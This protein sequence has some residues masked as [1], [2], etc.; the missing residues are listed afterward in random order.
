MSHAHHERTATQDPPRAWFHI[1]FSTYGTWLR[2]DARGFRDHDHRIHSSGDYRSPPPPDEHAGLRIWTR[3]HMHKEPVR[4]TPTQ[5]V[6][7]CA[8]LVEL[9]QAK[10]ARMLII[11]VALDHVHALGSFPVARLRTI[12]GHAKKYSSYALRSEIQGAVW[13]RKCRPKRVKDIDQQR[14]TFAYIKDHATQGAAI[15]IAPRE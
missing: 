7:T 4:L 12:V 15:W 2:G 9:F 1:W 5:R 13:A 3:A 8:K 11:A 6:S 14:A 10:S